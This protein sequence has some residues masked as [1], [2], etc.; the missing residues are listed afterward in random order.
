[1]ARAESVSD[2]TVCQKCRSK[3]AASRL[4]CPRCGTRF[5][6]ANPEREAAHSKRLALISGTALVLALIGLGVVYMQ[7]PVETES[8]VTTPVTDP[9]AARRAASAAAVAAAQEAALAPSVPTAGAQAIDASGDGAR[10]L[11]QYRDAVQRRPEDAD[12]RASLGQLLVRLKRIDEAVPHFERAIA[13]DPQNAAHHLQLG[14]ALAQLQHWQDAVQ[15]LRRAQQ[16]QP[17]DSG[18]AY[19]LAR[20]LHS[21]RDHAAAVDEYRKVIGLDPNDASVRIALAE[22]YEAMDRRQDA[23]A[24]YND[25]L[26]LA[27]TGTDADRVRLK[28]SRLGGQAPAA[29]TQ[30]GGAE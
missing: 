7:Q 29:G 8:A 17:T 28:L 13:L 16:L 1:V 22:S 10:L 26:K 27:P 5:A 9:L 12:A 6:I 4:S 24:A 15:S 11:D 14:A 2:I 21:N 25:Y 19:E 20:A 3:V 23:A 30:P 18:T